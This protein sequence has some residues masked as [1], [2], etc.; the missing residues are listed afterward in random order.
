M[1]KITT[2]LLILGFLMFSCKNESTTATSKENEGIAFNV[3]EGFI[4][5][6]LYQPGTNEQGSWVA[7]TQGPNDLIFACDQYGEIYYFDA[8][9]IDSK[10]DKKDVHPLNLEIGE[11]HGL[12]WA[13]NSLYVA[14]NKRWDDDVP[15]EE[16]NGSGF[17]SP[18][19]KKAVCQ[20]T[21]V[22]TICSNPI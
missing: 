4:L 10:L 22:K 5:E 16:E 9:A 11:A 2:T 7:L 12:L 15:D 14:V 18:L 8:P 21:G 13:F 3:P 6:D 19:K 17:L 1:N 20:P